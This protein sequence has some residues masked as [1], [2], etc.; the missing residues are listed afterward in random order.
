M[1]EVTGNLFCFLFLRFWSKPKQRKTD[2][3]YAIR[4]IS[5]VMQACLTMTANFV[6][7]SW[8]SRSDE[9]MK[10]LLTILSLGAIYFNMQF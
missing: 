7:I 4:F 3:I 10:P 2:Q 6:L 1:D 5:V 9:F 8:F